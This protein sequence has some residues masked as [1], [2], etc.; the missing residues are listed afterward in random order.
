MTQGKKERRF[1]L[2]AAEVDEVVTAISGYGGWVI[3][4]LHDLGYFIMALETAD[5]RLLVYLTTR[6]SE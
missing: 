5:P 6:L 2:P 1:N 3:R 4:Y